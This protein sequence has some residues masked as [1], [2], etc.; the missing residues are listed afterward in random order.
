[1]R[2]HTPFFWN[3][4]L[5]TILVLRRIGYQSSQ[6]VQWAL[7]DTV[8][9]SQWRLGTGP[10]NHFMWPEA[11]WWVSHSC[12]W[13]PAGSETLCA[14]PVKLWFTTVSHSLVCKQ[15][16]GTT[17]RHHHFNDFIARSLASAS[18]LVSKEPLGLSRSWARFTKNRKC[19]LW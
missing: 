8:R 17:V 10:A 7:F 9:S 18:I 12:S 1:M 4:L 6:T 14:S 16:P 5:G 11:W 3:S 19:Y 15:A 2:C 13:N